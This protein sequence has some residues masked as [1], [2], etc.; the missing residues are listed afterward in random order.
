MLSLFLVLISGCS[1]STVE[2]I[3][4]GDFGYDYYPL[5][6]G[7]S[8]F[9][10]VDSVI[11]RQGTGERAL[12]DSS[13]TLFREVIVD[14][15]RDNTGAL[16]YRIERYER[17][18]EQSP[19]QITKVLT[20]SRNATQ[21]LRT[22]DNLRFIKLVFPLRTGKEWDGNRFLSGT[23]NFEGSTSSVNIFKDW[24]DYRV[25]AVG[26][27]ETVA[28]QAYDEVTTVLQTEFE[29]ATDW[30]YAKEQYA[31]GIGLVYREWQI[32]HT[33]CKLCCEMDFSDCISL[34]W[35]E[36]VEDGFTLKQRLLRYE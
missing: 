22:E 31:K 16:V 18:D 33:Q 34:T 32:L 20:A 36:K 28:G 9:Y 23:V 7:R 1:D 19:W 2:D 13:R 12:R 25:E 27:P 14:T 35:E 6:V 15:L 5:E 3:N 24:Q 11:F 26:Q 29:S 10:E 17:P 30:R 21:A 4:T 8:Y